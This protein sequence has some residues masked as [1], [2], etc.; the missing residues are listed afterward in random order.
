[1]T[2]WDASVPVLADIV[3]DESEGPLPTF[4]PRVPGPSGYVLKSFATC[5]KHRPVEMRQPLSIH[6]AAEPEVIYDVGR[7]DKRVTMLSC[8]V[9]QSREP[10]LP[11][12]FLGIPAPAIQRLQSAHAIRV[13]LSLV[14][15]GPL[16][17][18]PVAEFEPFVD[19]P[20]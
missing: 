13:E 5:R 6:P 9:E 17:L 10:T 7:G 1:M 11:L 16:P 19:Q 18:Y 15:G 12:L 14:V 3:P 8:V 2:I 20:A 4:S